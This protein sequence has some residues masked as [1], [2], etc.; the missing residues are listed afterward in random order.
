MKRAVRTVAC[1]IATA[2]VAFVL[3]GP[4]SAN[5]APETSDEEV[6]QYDGTNDVCHDGIRF[7]W[8]TDQKSDALYLFGAYNPATELA[9]EVP[10]H[11]VAVDPATR[12]LLGEGDAYVPWNPTRTLPWEYYGGSSTEEDGIHLLEGGVTFAFPGVW[13]PA[14]TSSVILT[15]KDDPQWPNFPAVK[16]KDCYRYATVTVGRRGLGTVQVILH[17]TSHLCVGILTPSKFRIKFAGALRMS[18]EQPLFSSV[19]DVDGDGHADLVLT[20]AASASRTPVLLS[21]ATFTGGLLQG[22]V[23]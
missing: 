3:A 16:V 23:S 10:F 11:L 12:Q 14:T 1:A 6:A 22:A 2:V 5:W 4:A 20:Y 19:T 8:A 17:G 21:G 13:E 7:D 9:A 18:T 15:P